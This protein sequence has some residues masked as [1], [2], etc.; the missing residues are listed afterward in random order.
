M[1]GADSLYYFFSNTLYE[2]GIYAIGCQAAFG[3]EP[4]MQCTTGVPEKPW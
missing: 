2:Q 3:S 1:G 4:S